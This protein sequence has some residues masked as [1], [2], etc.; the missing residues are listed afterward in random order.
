[1]RRTLF[2][3]MIWCVVPLSPWRE[4]L[5]IQGQSRNFA[6]N[7]GEGLKIHA[8]RNA[9]TAEAKA[10]RELGK[11]AR[12]MVHIAS[13][14]DFRSLKHH[15]GRRSIAFQCS[16][17]DLFSGLEECRSQIA[18]VVKKLL[19]R[20]LLSLSSYS[21]NLWSCN[22]DAICA[23]VYPWSHAALPTSIFPLYFEGILPF[24]SLATLLCDVSEA[25]ISS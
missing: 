1:M 4:F 24:P 9:Q 7:P 14:D 25:D 20:L 22:M 11:L 2:T 15:V 18:K 17:V 10:D 13:I 6:L 21:R 8:F 12:Y 5:L 19:D 3:S 16:Q 23:E